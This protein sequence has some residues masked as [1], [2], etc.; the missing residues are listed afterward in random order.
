MDKDLADAIAAIDDAYVEAERRLFARG[1]VVIGVADDPALATFAHVLRNAQAGMA[2]PFASAFAF[3]DA[4][5][6]TMR[7]TPMSVPAPS[8]VAGMLD[9]RFQSNVAAFLAWRLVKQPSLPEWRAMT[10]LLYCE[11]QRDPAALP[12]LVRF[13]STTANDELFALARRCVHAYDGVF[14]A[15]VA[16]LRWRKG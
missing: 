6:E 9:H 3:F 11:R 8:M 5:E 2:E 15:L 12:A 13:L 1:D 7:G 14:D 4:I 10:V 16:E